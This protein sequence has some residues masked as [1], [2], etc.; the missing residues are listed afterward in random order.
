MGGKRRVSLGMT[1]IYATLIAAAQ[2][3]FLVYMNKTGW[4]S[5]IGFIVDIGFS[6]FI[7]FKLVE[8]K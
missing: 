7:L 2:V 4:L 3:G 6:S 1:I 8:D 5:A